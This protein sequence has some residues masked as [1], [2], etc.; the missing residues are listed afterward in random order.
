MGRVLVTGANGFTGAHLLR[1]LRAAGHEI[2]GMKRPG[3][4]SDEKMIACEITDYD[5]L[6]ASIGD[7]RPEFVIHLAGLSFAALDDT[8]A[9][10]EINYQGTETLLRA[11]RDTVPNLKKAVLASS[12]TVYGRPDIQI[13][14]ETLCP[15]PIN[16]YGISKLAME[17]MAATFCDILPIIMTRPFNYTGIGQEGHF[18]IPKI[19]DHFARQAPALELGN[20]KVWRDFMD[21]RDTARAYRLLMECDEDGVTTNLCSGRLNSLED[22][23]DLAAELTGYRPE[24]KVNP[25]FVRANEIPKLRGNPDR[26]ASLIGQQQHIP[27][28]DTIEW[29]LASS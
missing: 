17:Q 9:Y 15:Q 22:I 3:S 18:L 10:F 25:A 8:L 5:A 2:L 12:A 27:L 24:I 20:I 6:C 4:S 21:V 7:F 16:T 26:L 11:L 28:R 1:D 14:D 23:L 19:V 29:M 13:L